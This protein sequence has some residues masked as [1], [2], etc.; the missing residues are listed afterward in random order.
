MGLI[1]RLQ[2]CF[3]LSR[4]IRANKSN[5]SRLCFRSGRSLNILEFTVSRGFSS[6]GLKEVGGVS[7]GNDGEEGKSESYVD[8][9][10]KY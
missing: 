6:F 10:C 8:L 9:L 1:E 7:S 5:N 4:D 3:R 2:L